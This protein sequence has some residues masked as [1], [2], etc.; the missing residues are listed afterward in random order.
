M[1]PQR[2]DV[3]ALGAVLYELLSPA[4][5]GRLDPEVADRAPPATHARPL[6]QGGRP[7]ALD[8]VVARCLA[9][10]PST[11]Y[12]TADGSRMRSGLPLTTAA[13]PIMVAAR[14]GDARHRA[15]PAGR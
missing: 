14:S 12:P 6:D 11:R 9:K 1:S 2:V 7:Q 4:P 8:E 10:D 5:R 13:E 3:Y 15:G